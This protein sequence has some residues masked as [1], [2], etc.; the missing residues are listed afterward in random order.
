[1][2]FTRYWVRPRQ[3][4][5]DRFRSF[6]DACKLECSALGVGLL[7]EEFTTESISFDGIPSCERFTIEC[8]SQGRE[9]DG[10]ITEYCKTQGLPYDKAVVA[11]L[12]LLKEHFPEVELPEPS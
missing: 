2:G 11:C 6:A 8:V 1:M 7:A 4:E 3:L 5:R 9:R 10:R 12:A